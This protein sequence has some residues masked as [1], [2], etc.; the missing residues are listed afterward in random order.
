MGLRH[1]VQHDLKQ[2]RFFGPQPVDKRPVQQLER[3]PV[4]LAVLEMRVERDLLAFCV[5]AV[6]GSTHAHVGL[7][8]GPGI[9][10]EHGIGS[11]MD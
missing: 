9:E 8:D 4:D 1:F 10:N 11:K 5:F 6:H 2:G 3:I 7:E